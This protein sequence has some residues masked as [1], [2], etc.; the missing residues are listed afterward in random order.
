MAE[1]ANVKSINTIAD[2][3]ARLKTYIDS[4]RTTISEAHSDVLRVQRW[5]D[6]T[7]TH[8]WSMRLK[9]C[10]QLLANAKSDLERA[11]I[12]RP[13]AHP[14]TFVDQQR[15][16]RKAKS[17]LEECEYKIKAIK[18]WSRELDR[19]GMIFKGHLNQ[20][21]RAVEGDLNRAATWLAKLVEHL[22]A[23][24]SSPP[25]KLPEPEHSL[26]AKPSRRRAGSPQGD[27]HEPSL[28]EVEAPEG[29]T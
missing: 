28:D 27:P 3:R 23:Y 21:D 25:P 9:K 19:E 8:Q 24:S 4:A 6:E 2:F 5:I 13:D 20:L 22:E 12:S 15:A 14:T 11:K 1:R 18:R 10:R 7:Q 16:V 29:D 17:N 26:E